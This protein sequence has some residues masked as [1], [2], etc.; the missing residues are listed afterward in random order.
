MPCGDV[1]VSEYVHLYTH[2]YICNRGDV[3]TNCYCGDG[4]VELQ[5]GKSPPLLRVYS[6]LEQWHQNVL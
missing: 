5:V 1:H 3:S 4:G 2:D 6:S